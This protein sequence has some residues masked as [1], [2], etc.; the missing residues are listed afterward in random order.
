MSER[1]PDSVMLDD[2]ER[3]LEISEAET[4]ADDDVA[5]ADIFELCRFIDAHGR[6]L[7][8]LARTC[9]AALTRQTK[10]PPA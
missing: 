7:L 1:P 8:L 2:F 10:G 3:L 9:E 4:A 5:Y 6:R